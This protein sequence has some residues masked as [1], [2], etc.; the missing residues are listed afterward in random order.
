MTCL[1]LMPKLSHPHYVFR[2]VSYF[3]GE[4]Y[5]EEEF[6]RSVVEDSWRV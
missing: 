3:N 4:R 6:G 1:K 2:I 5:I